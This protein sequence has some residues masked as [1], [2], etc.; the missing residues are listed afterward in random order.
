MPQWL[1]PITVLTLTPMETPVQAEI[2]SGD[3][4][5]ADLDVLPLPD[6]VWLS[7]PHLGEEGI[8]LLAAS[9]GN[10][11]GCYERKVDPY[12]TSM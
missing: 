6:L 11:F 8:T 3:N 7:F 4:F 9:G 5:N 10:D 2:E 12:K 1:I